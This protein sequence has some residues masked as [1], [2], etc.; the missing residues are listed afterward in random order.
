MA[1]MDTLQRRSRTRGLTGEEKERAEFI[2]ECLKR[3]KK[4]KEVVEKVKSLR[5]GESLDAYKELRDVIPNPIIANAIVST[6]VA[7]KKRTSLPAFASFFNTSAIDVVYYIDGTPSPLPL[8]YHKLER[9][10]S[11]K[12]KSIPAGQWS[13]LE[14]KEPKQLFAIDALNREHK[15]I[16][17]RIRMERNDTDIKADVAYLLDL[18]RGEAESLKINLKNPK[19]QWG[20]LKNYLKIYDLYQRYRRTEDKG[21]KRIGLEVYGVSSEA[22]EKAA[23]RAKKAFRKAEALINGGWQ[24]L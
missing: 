1:K 2:F 8:D 17:I 24:Q 20:K 15:T 4:V 6:L 21:W 16:T 13:K 22:I 3:N 10:V 11:E 9:R 7:S 5:P 14:M 18:V 19:H 23:D 12:R